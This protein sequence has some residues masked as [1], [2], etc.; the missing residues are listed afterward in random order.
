MEIQWLNI[1]PK[2]ENKSVT[3]ALGEMSIGEQRIAEPFDSPAIRVA[4]CNSFHRK[5]KAWFTTKKVWVS[6]IES[7]RNKGYWACL[8]TREE[9]KQPTYKVPRNIKVTTYRD[10]NILGVLRVSEGL[11]YLDFL[12]MDSC[13]PVKEISQII[14]TK[15]QSFC[16]KN[17]VKLTSYD[18]STQSK[19]PL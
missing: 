7:G 5:N 18:N 19:I 13:E 3:K 6:V 16:I 14:V 12:Y 4:I 10:N 1:Y 15:V 2:E 8:I 11:G 17:N 9:D